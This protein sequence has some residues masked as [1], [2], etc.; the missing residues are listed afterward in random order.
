MGALLTTL[1]K[2]AEALSHGR[3]TV[4]LEITDDADLL[5]SLKELHSAF[6]NLV[7]NAVRYTPTGGRIHIRWRRTP[8]GAVF[9]VSDTG[10]GIPLSHQARLTERFYRVSSS[11]S[12]ETGG[13]GLGLSIVKHVLNLHQ[14]RLTVESE[15]GRGSTF[16][17]EFGARR[18]LEPGGGEA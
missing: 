11:R 5:G 13:T 1:R 17:A 15:P 14:A 2:E 12:R 18:V 3:H 10:Y 6:S 4:T 7:S 9:A 8:E 16:A